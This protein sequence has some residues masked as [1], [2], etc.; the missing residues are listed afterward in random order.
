MAS[1]ILSSGPALAMVTAGSTVT[2][3]DTGLPVQLLVEIGVMVY[4]TVPGLVPPLNKM[5]LIDVTPAATVPV[6]FPVTAPV[7]VLVQVYRVVA[8]RLEDSVIAEDVLLQITALAGVA[9]STGL[10]V[11]VTVKVKG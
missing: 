7:T 9:V 5:S 6:L 11:I 4:V 10:G 3:T 1:Q 2:V 8:P